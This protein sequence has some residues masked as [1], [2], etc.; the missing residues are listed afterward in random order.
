MNRIVRRRL[1]MAVRVR[2]FSRAH[3]SADANYAPV[4]ARLED[5]ISRLETLAS[6]SRAATSRR[7]RRRRAG[8]GSAGGCTTSCCGTW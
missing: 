5:R 3:P 2:D 7:A 1:E 6:S 4:L 8:A